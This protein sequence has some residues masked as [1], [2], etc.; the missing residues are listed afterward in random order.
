MANAIIDAEWRLE[1]AEDAAMRHDWASVL[2]ELEHAGALVS[3]AMMAALDE[4]E[5]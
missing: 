2:R 1:A 3:Q 5:L 4:V